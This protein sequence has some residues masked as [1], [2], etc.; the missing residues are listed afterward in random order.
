MLHWRVYSWAKTWTRRGSRLYGYWEEDCCR[1]KKTACAKTS[2]W[3]LL[4][5]SKEQR[6]GPH[7]VSTG[8]RLEGRR[9]RGRTLRVWSHCKGSLG[10]CFWGR[11]GQEKVLLREV[12]SS[13]SCFKRIVCLW[14]WQE[15]LGGQGETGSF[16]EAIC[17]LSVRDDGG[18][19]GY[20]VQVEHIRLSV[21]LDTGCVNFG[22]LVK[23]CPSGFSR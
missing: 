19:A 16:E 1:Q 10:L 13:D 4:N 23:V 12:T 7:S 20:D 21:G 14:C 2:E 18:L 17:N 9:P 15:T 22:A 6:I 5:A 11:W 8:G 3:G